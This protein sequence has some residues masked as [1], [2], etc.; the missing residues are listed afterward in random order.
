MEPSRRPALQTDRQTDRQTTAPPALACAAG[1]ATWAPPS[2][3][4]QLPIPAT[5][6]LCVHLND[7]TSL[8]HEQRRKRGEGRGRGALKF[9]RPG[10]DPDPGPG[11]GPGLCSD[12][13]TRQ[14]RFIIERARRLD[15][16]GQHLQRPIVWSFFFFFSF[17]FLFSSSSSSFFSFIVTP[18]LLVAYSTRSSAPRRLSPEKRAAD[19]LRKP[20]PPTWSTA[21][22]PPRAAL[23]AESAR[24]E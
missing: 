24:S 14:P 18:T 15:R 19:G 2:S 23:T 13:G 16:A 12:P 21:A 11:L 10:S 17:F 22:S 5:P 6:T 1:C 9:G 4:S 3:P 7:F 20:L 8:V